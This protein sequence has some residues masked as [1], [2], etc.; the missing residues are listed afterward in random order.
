VRQDIFSPERKH[1]QRLVNLGCV[2][3]QPHPPI[4]I[5]AQRIDGRVRRRSRRL[6]LSSELLRRQERA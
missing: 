3:Q 2:I 1:Y 4:W 6:L 5:L